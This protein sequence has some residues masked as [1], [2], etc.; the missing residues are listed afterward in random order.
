MDQRAWLEALYTRYHADVFRFALSILRERT[1][2][3][4]VTQE[5]FLKAYRGF[6]TYRAQGRERAWLFQI[7]RR[8]AYDHLRR[9]RREL[10]WEAA[11]QLWSED[12]RPALAVLECIGSL[13][14]LDRDIVGLKVIAGLTHR[15][16]A[17]V[18]GRSEQGVKK[19]YERALE[20][21]REQWREEKE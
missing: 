15:E 6:G 1:A 8:T 18:L 17:R 4:D 20:K 9:A 21:L 16:I 7:A 13:G 14:A 12:E 19:R 3:E 10:P 11:E 2:A 5:A